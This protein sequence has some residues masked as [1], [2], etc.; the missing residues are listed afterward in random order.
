L[1]KLLLLLQMIENGGGTCGRIWQRHGQADPHG[2]ETLDD[3]DDYA[4]ACNEF[5]MLFSA[6]P[7]HISGTATAF[8]LNRLAN[9]YILCQIWQAKS[10]KFLAE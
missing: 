10:A 1:Q 4:E 2:L 3:D 8:M 5:A 7:H 9:R 6:T